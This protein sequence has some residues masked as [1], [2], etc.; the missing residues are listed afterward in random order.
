MSLKK[1]LYNLFLT[2]LL[3]IPFNLYAY[4]DYIVA[5]GENVGIR[6]FSDGVLIIGTYEI[7]GSDPANDA[8][9]KV[10]D[11]ITSINKE[12]I[13]SVDEMIDVINSSRNKNVK[14]EYKRDSDTKNTTL[15]LIKVGDTLKTG[16]YVKDSITG[17]G[18]LTYIDPNTKIFGALGHEII[19]SITKEI[20]ESKN[21]T[22]FESA[23]TGITKSNNGNP[24]EK[25][26]TFDSSKID[27]NIEENTNKGIFGEYIS[28][29]NQE[30][31][32]KVAT[33]KDIKLGKAQIKTVLD[34]DEVGKYDIDIISVSNTDDKI[35]N[36]VFEITDKKLIEK[37]NGIVQ[38]MS[39]S[40]IIQG[41][42][43][44]G[45]VTHV[46]IDDPLK[47]YG[48][49]ITNMLEEGEN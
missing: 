9:L 25:N 46:V 45:A 49:L 6:I 41:N 10:G 30:E 3:F 15:N 16:L 14:I 28:E 42:Y 17:I 19:D 7:N 34:G 47:G 11:I 12:K 44:I 18:T 24:G 29:I 39:G 2:L 48:I 36:I 32:Y 23:V 33:I 38:G 31:L 1:R 4:S 22:I 8:G 37:T 13:T 35:K 20:I 43:I 21:G 27:G 26:A 40:P 5:S